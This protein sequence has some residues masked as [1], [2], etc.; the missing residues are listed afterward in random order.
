VFVPWALP[1]S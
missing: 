1:D